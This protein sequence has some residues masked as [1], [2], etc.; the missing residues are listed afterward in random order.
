NYAFEASS[1]SL[2]TE[3]GAERFER[4]L[5]VKRQ[6]DPENVFRFNHNIAAATTV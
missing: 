2:E 5:A 4:L 3:F 1:E 6:F